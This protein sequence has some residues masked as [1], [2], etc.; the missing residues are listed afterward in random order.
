M[1][2]NDFLLL[3]SLIIPL[4][5]FSIILVPDII[6]WKRVREEFKVWKIMRHDLGT[7]PTPEQFHEFIEKHPKFQSAIHRIAFKLEMTSAMKDMMDLLRDILKKSK[8]TW[9]NDHD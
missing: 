6:K 8:M 9:M 4:I 7:S 2:I 3:T 5:V 1:T